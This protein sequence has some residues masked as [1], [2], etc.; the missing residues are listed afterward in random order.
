[1]RKDFERAYVTPHGPVAVVTLNHPEALNA[2]SVKMLKGLTAALDHIARDGSFRAIVMTGEG[3]GFCSGANLTEIPEEQQSSAGVGSALE[4]AYHPFLRRLRDLKMPFVTAVNG[5]A[6][7][8]GMSIA[9]MGDIILAGRSAYFLQAFARIGLVPDG[10]STW[11]L[12]RLVGLARAR[13]LSMLAE[14]LPAEKALEWGLINQVHDDAA[15]M[16]SA[17]KIATRLADGPTQ[18]LAMIRRLY[19]DSPHNSY[20]A[21]IDAERQAQGRAGRTADF[22]EGVTAFAQKRPAKFTGK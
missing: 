20:E 19:W 9:L 1:M 11:L 8:V 21:Q 17:L 12:P 10:G 18:S 7:G 5:A 4:T 3:R 15:L 2:A 16:E 6:A 13:E 22:V 14:K